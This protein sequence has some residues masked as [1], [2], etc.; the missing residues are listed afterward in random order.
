MA[1][2]FITHKRCGTKVSSSCLT[3]TSRRVVHSYTQCV[4]TGSR[5]QL[6]QQRHH[7]H[8]QTDRQTGTA[9]AATINARGVAAGHMCVTL[10]PGPGRPRS[11]HTQYYPCLPAPA[12]CNTQS[13]SLPT[14][15]RAMLHVLTYTD[16]CLCLRCC[17]TPECAQPPCQHTH[18]H[19]SSS[20]R[21]A[22]SGKSA[23]RLRVSMP[24]PP[25]TP[26]IWLAL[27]AAASLVSRNMKG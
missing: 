7:T 3:N 6:R 10:P 1:E 16:F 12:H 26:D 2:A 24:S 27:A 23:R 17:C 18:T 21:A 11:R 9:A 13:A 14:T 4:N 25:A 15:C 8:V 22:P 19:L 20:S 5:H